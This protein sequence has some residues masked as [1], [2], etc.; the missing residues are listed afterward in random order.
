M[1]LALAIMGVCAIV[2][3]HS[4]TLA[5]PALQ[6]TEFGP[7]LYPQIIATLL[8]ITAAIYLVISYRLTKSADPTTGF[9]ES[10]KVITRGQK[11]TVA[12]SILLCF[13]YLPLMMVLGYYIGTGV[14]LMS[15]FYLLG[16]RRWLTLFGVSIGFLVVAYLI[17]ERILYISF[18]MGLW[19]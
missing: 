13:G 15:S 16:V 7:R 2:F 9:E 17:F 18:P 6:S 3:G 12:L 11:W 5:P 8:F 1:V 10:T 19:G 14:F 4:L